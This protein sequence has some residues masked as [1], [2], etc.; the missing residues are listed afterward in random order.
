MND[1]GDNYQANL[2]R[3]VGLCRCA[4]KCNMSLDVDANAPNNVDTNLT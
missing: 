2:G 3:T 4:T 1:E